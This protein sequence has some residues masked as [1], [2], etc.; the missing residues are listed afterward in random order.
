MAV[1]I[2]NCLIMIRL[3]SQYTEPKERRDLKNKS[4]D[5]FQIIKQYV[6]TKIK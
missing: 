3:E 6:L 5:T 4:Q 2:P 1:L